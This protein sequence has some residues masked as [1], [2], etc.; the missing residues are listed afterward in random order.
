MAL[1]LIT[2]ALNLR[3]YF[4]AH[5]IVVRTEKA[6]QKSTSTRMAIWSQEIKEY[7]I[8]FHPRMTMKGQVVSYFIAEFT[9]PTDG[10]KDDESKDGPLTPIKKQM[11][12]P[13]GPIWTFHIDGPSNA[14]CSGVWV[15][16]TNP[17]GGKHKYT[18][19]F[20]SK[21][22]TTRRNTNLSWLA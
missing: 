17:D 8:E 10:I 15:V 9:C 6:L 14:H 5:Q 7:G 11:A 18:L 2:A 13:D 1:A 22:L 4:L 19:I 21:P 16:L 20:S 12:D 3:L